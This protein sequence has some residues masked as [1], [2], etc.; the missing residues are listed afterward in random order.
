VG[1]ASGGQVTRRAVLRWGGLLAVAPLA[2]CTATPQPAPGPTTDEVLAGRVGDAA[3]A[4]HDEYRRTIAAHPATAG[5][6]AGFADHHA[7]HLTA[8]GRPVPGAAPSATATTP[9]TGS[10]SSPAATPGPVDPDPGRAVAEL[11]ESERTARDAALAAAVAATD[12]RLARLLA[13][14]AASRAQHT[15]ALAA[16]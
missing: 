5:R 11:A 10:P 6:L 4:L 14:I 12:P 7:A 9:A 16:S 13:G 8:L 1:P 3:V 15:D 2:G